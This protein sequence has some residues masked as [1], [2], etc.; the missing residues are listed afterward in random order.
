MI[1]TQANIKA[2]TLRYE[3]PEISVAD[4]KAKLPEVLE[5]ARRHQPQLIS[6]RGRDLVALLA[7]DDA[8]QVLGSFRFQTEVHLAKGEVTVALPQFELI[9]I[10]ESVDAAA[11]D[12]LDKLREYA[13]HYLKRASF[14]RE[15]N[16]RDLYPLVLRF[17][18]TPREQQHE[19][20]L[21]D[22]DE[23]GAASA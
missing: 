20:L 8:Q 21:E 11:E 18:L 3:V 12:A 17:V 23:V 13:A 9:G 2:M 4:A 6:R 15:T 5:E 16:R 22:P 14:Y 10:G 1:V 7:L 19:L